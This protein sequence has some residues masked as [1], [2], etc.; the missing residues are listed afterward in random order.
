MALSGHTIKKLDMPLPRQKTR[1]KQ[2][3]DWGHIAR[4]G[5]IV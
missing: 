1:M 3:M 4:V 5:I 2:D